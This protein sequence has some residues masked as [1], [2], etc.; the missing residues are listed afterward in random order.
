MTLVLAH[1]VT[2]LLAHGPG[3]YD[4]AMSANGHD[5]YWSTWV[6]GVPIAA[7]LLVVVAAWQIRRLAGLVNGR[8]SGALVDGRP[9]DYLRSV[10]YWWLRLLIGVTLLFVLQENAEHLRVGAGMPGLD[11]L[12]TG[13][14]GP[15]VPVIAAVSVLVSTAIGL[16][17]WCRRSLLAGAQAQTPTPHAQRVRRSTATADRQ[18][19]SLLLARRGAGRAPPLPA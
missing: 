13:E 16:F 19:I 4:A 3:G 2:Y 10:T 17:E 18:L 15:A 11:V 14:Y 1:H 9:R 12:W 6:G 5:E 8:E 7:V